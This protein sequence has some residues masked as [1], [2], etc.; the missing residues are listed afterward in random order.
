MPWYIFALLSNF[1]WGLG[2]Q[3]YALYSKK[4][5]PVW[6]NIFKGTFAGILFTI[7]VLL[8]GGFS[9]IPWQGAALFMLSGFIGLGLGDIFLLKSFSVIGTSRTIMLSAFSP[10]FVGVMSYFAF[11]QTVNK[12]KLLSIIFLIIC[13]LIFS[14]E[15]YRKTSRWDFKIML[16]ALLGVFLDG[17][18]VVISRTAFNISALGTME[19]NVYRCLGA[20]LSFLIITR[21]FKIQFFTRLKKLSKRALVTLCAGT[22]VGSY[23]CLTFYLAAIKTG[24][25][26]TV[27]AMI[28]TGVIFAAF[29]ECLIQKKWPSKYLLAAFAFFLCAIYILFATG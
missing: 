4:I 8:T 19:A 1:S 7:T 3:F 11:G 27:A 16:I 23:L 15:N 20:A 26:A 18:G 29:F 5:S 17:V 2:S 13:V 21:V 6:T 14:L 24:H 25:L 12:T 9:S 28:T 22:F 10:L